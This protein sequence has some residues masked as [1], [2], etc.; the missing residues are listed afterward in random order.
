M[1]NTEVAITL[2][3]YQQVGPVKG[4]GNGRKEEEA[5]TNEGLLGGEG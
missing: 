3:C 1:E 4:E 5:L 2:F